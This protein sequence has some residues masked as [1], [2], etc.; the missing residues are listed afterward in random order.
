M[1]VSESSIRP[2]FL[3][4]SQQFSFLQDRVVSPTPNPHPGEL[5]LCI[6]ISQRRGGPVNTPMHRVPIL[7]ASYDTHWLRWDY[8]YSPVTTWGTWV[9]GWWNNINV[10]IFIRY[11]ANSIKF[12]IFLFLLKLILKSIIRE[13]GL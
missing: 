12:A 4:A 8:S 13:C 2:N 6:Y 7:V 5:G 1:I 3:E 9:L 11:G 10:V